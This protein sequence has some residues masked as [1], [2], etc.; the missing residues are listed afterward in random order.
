M[1]T[2]GVS[3]TVAVLLHEIPQELAAADLIPELQHDRSARALFVQTALISTGIAVM[4]LL[5]VVG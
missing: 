4:G 5:A 2:L 3:T 1:R